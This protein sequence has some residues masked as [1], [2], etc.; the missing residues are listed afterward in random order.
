M[1]FDVLLVWGVQMLHPLSGWPSP[2]LDQLHG[3]KKASGV[4]TFRTPPPST[5]KSQDA[6]IIR[7]PCFHFQ[8]LDDSHRL[9][10][11][12]FCRL[13]REQA[14]SFGTLAGD[15]AAESLSRWGPAQIFSTLSPNWDEVALGNAVPRRPAVMGGVLSCW[16]PISAGRW[17]DSGLSR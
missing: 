16:V 1:S 14:P 7:N 12:P 2:H 8:E 5:S 11:K 13:V 4:P 6:E 15:P 10:F 9:V 17:C 3:L